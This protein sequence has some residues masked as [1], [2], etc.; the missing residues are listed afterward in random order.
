MTRVYFPMPHAAA[1]IPHLDDFRDHGKEID[2]VAMCTHLPSG[3]P[4]EPQYEIPRVF[5]E[6]LEGFEETFF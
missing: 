2:E 3:Y 4:N 6:G 5:N 1:A